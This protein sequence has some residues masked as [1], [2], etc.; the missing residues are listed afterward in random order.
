MYKKLKTM[1]KNIKRLPI[2]PKEIYGYGSFFREKEKIGDVDIH[3]EYDDHTNQRWEDFD[4][5]HG[6]A[7]DSFRRGATAGTSKDN[8]KLLEGKK[9]AAADDYCD[10]P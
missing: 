9:F 7:Y 4:H 5:H 8:V 3:I 1:F 2:K 10:A 6:R